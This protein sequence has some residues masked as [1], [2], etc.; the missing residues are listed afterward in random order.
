M[1]LVGEVMSDQW[2]YRI[3]GQEF[4]PVSLD[5][6]RNLVAAGTI[7]VDD[8]VRDLNSSKWTLACAATELCGS[9][10]A[11]EPNVER[12]LGR[13]EWYCQGYAGEVGPLSMSDLIQLAADGDL[14]PDEQIKSHVD[15][16]WRQIN[17][18]RRLVELLPF[19]D[20]PRPGNRPAFSFTKNEAA[21]SEPAD[22][23]PFPGVWSQPQLPD[24]RINDL[25]DQ[26][27]NF[28]GNEDDQQDVST[29]GTEKPN[30]IGE[31]VRSK[32][33][34]IGGK[35]VPFDPILPAETE[36]NERWSGWIAGQEF[37]PVSFSELLSWAVTGRLAPMDFVRKGD[38][39]QFVPAVNIPCLFTVENAACSLARRIHPGDL[40]IAAEPCELPDTG[41]G[42]ISKRV[43]Q[44]N[45]TTEQGDARFSG[46]LLSFAQR[47]LRGSAEDS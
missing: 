46:R 33:L 30:E 42:D 9:A 39:G 36:S 10:K 24:E 6:V 8:E 2:L 40:K 21:N 12:R 31:A 18:I 34:S 1:A 17:S 29:H 23:L 5:L 20:E 43:T 22:I 19:P 7:A 11:S 38:E 37:G 16:Y 35:P 13:D 15:D 4:G 47:L 27:K 44:P 26:L 45:V 3:R 28:I 14:R 41:R 25:I 32:K